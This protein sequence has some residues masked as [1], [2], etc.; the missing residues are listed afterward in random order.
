MEM[1]HKDLNLCSTGCVYLCMYVSL[2]SGLFLCVSLFNSVCV[3]LPPPFSGPSSLL[4]SV[5]L[6][7][8]CLLCC[9]LVAQ[10]YLFQLI[11]KV[12]YT[13]QGSAPCSSPALRSHL[14]KKTAKFL[15]T[16]LLILSILSKS[17]TIYLHF[18]IRL[19]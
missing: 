5:C 8:F 10:G 1:E 6:H 13:A 2:P 16:Q 14:R 17:T 19:H 9:H 3:R 7:S 18:V 12:N 15:W 11:S 4:F